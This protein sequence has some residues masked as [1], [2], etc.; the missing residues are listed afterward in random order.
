M[1]SSIVTISTQNFTGKKTTPKMVQH[2]KMNKSYLK[3]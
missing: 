2:F 1:I 3:I